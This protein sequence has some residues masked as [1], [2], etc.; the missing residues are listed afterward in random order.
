VKASSALGRS[1]DNESDVEI[2]DPK[3]F[4]SNSQLQTSF[5]AQ[6]KRVNFLEAQ[7]IAWK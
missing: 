4:M 5:R 6:S 2:E 3:E 1:V 7:R